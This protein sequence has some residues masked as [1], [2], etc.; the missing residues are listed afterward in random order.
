M[1]TDAANAPSAAVLEYGAY[2]RQLLTLPTKDIFKLHETPKRPASSAL[3]QMQIGK[4]GLHVYLNTTQRWREEQLE[5][6][7]LQKPVRRSYD[8]GNQDTQHVVFSLEEF[9]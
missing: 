8:I 2:A 9:P 3:I 5:A 1:A 6:N 4:I 7:P